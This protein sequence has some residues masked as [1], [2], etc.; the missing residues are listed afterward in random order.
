M[1]LDPV[2]SFATLKSPNPVTLTL[3]ESLFLDIAGEEHVLQIISD[4]GPGVWITRAQCHPDL[5]PGLIGEITKSGVG[6]LYEVNELDSD[7]DTKRG[8][9]MVFRLT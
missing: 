1:F 9:T 4:E 3:R 5:S 6:I 7:Y 8:I 2:P